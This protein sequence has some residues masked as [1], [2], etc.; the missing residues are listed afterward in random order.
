[1][2]PLTTPTRSAYPRSASYVR[3]A[4]STGTA[5]DFWLWRETS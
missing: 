1:M 3:T 5:T 4:V 2:S